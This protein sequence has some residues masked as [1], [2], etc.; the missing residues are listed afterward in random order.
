MTQNRMIVN[1]KEKIQNYKK[2]RTI[3][4]LKKRHYSVFRHIKSGDGCYIFG[5]RELGQF[6]AEQM[7]R[8]NIPLKGYIDNDEHCWNEE[9]KIYSPEHLTKN[10]IVIIASISY[11]EIVRQLNSLGIEL[12]IYYEELAF[13]IDGFE[14]YY[15]AFENIFDELEKNREEYLRIFN[16]L[17]DDISKDVY[18]NLL[19]FR[20]TLNHKYTL[21]AFTLS[22]R[23]GIQDFDKLVV[24]NITGE[25]CFYDVGGYDGQSTVD[26]IQSVKGYKKI[27]FF[28]PD[29]TIMEGTKRRL[30]R[31]K[32]I[33]YFSAALGDKD[34]E[35]Y[36]DN[37][38]GGNGR[39]CASGKQI[40]RMM[41][42]DDFVSSSESYVK[43]DVEG[44]ELSVLQGCEQAIR[45]YKPMLSV[46][47]YHKPGD[48]HVLI[49]KVMTWNP[50]YRV[51]M[52]HYTG[53]YAD[54]RAYFLDKG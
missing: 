32:N 45:N 41:R 54:T 39:V 37:S 4:N 30:C 1:V 47:L 20:M 33:E 3:D 36:Y 19:E 53:T 28:E 24:D 16:V 34:T 17:E 52:R 10:D 8:N 22:L 6:C 50:N 11:P 46:S 26:F 44:F 38:G 29:K 35:I 7:E 12:V 43:I 49:N 31:Y 27:F 14:T 18:R 5:T 40:V 13:I 23:Q 9:K 21:E 25:T 51:Y 48:I 2:E 15:M 42:L